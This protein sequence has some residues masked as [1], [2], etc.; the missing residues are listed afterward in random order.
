MYNS[1]S[2]KG[3]T[4]HLPVRGGGQEHTG[5]EI[6]VT[7]TCHSAL[8]SL[9]KGGSRQGRVHGARHQVFHFFLFSSLSYFRVIIQPFLES[10]HKAEMDE[11]LWFPARGDEA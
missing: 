5:Q 2:T 6:P 3:L 8:Y 1:S 10:S 4:D 7:Q 9:A 11:Q